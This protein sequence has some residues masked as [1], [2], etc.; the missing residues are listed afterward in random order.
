[1]TD[2]FDALNKRAQDEQAA[3]D[4]GACLQCEKLLAAIARLRARLEHRTGKH[5][6]HPNPDCDWCGTHDAQP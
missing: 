4:A 1:M 6:L 5:G 2:P 3:R